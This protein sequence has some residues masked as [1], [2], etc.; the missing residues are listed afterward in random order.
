M[1]IRTLTARAVFVASVLGLLAGGAAAQSLLLTQNVDGDAND[2]I[3]ICD[4]EGAEQGEVLPGVEKPGPG[5][6]V[7]ESL[8]GLIFWAEENGGDHRILRSNFRSGEAATVLRSG[9]P[10]EVGGIG[11][12]TKKKFL[13]YTAGDSIYRMKI[14]G[15]RHKRVSHKVEQLGLDVGAPGAIVIDSEA[16]KVYWTDS[17]NDWIAK[18]EF[19]RNPPPAPLVTSAQIPI[20]DPKG[21]D[22]NALTG[23]LFWTDATLGTV[24]RAEM[25]GS[26]PTTVASNLADPDGVAID[27][28]ERTLLV[29]ESGADQVL[30]MGLDGSDPQPVVQQAGPCIVRI[31][32]EALAPLLEALTG[33]L[34]GF[35]NPGSVLFF[36]LV[37]TGEGRTQI[38][39]TNTNSNH[40]YCGLGQPDIFEGTVKVELRF[41]FPL[42]D[43]IEICGLSDDLICLTPNDTYTV[44]ADETNLQPDEVGW[45]MAFA[46]SVHTGEPIIFNHL[47]GSAQVFTPDD[48]TAWAYDA[49]SFRG[50]NLVDFIAGE[51]EYD[52]CG[53]PF[54]ESDIDPLSIEGFADFNDLEYDNFPVS[55]TLPVLFEES[56]PISNQL[57]VMSTARI[58]PDDDIF[59]PEDPGNGRTIKALGFNNSEEQK[60]SRDSDIICFVEGDLNDP[61]GP[62][63]YPTDNLMGEIEDT[64]FPD[65]RTDAGW[66]FFFLDFHRIPTTE[67]EF[68]D[69]RGILAT[70]AQFNSSDHAGG[71]NVWTGS[72]VLLE[73]FPILGGRWARFSFEGAEPPP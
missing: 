73:L 21:L 62:F 2:R 31:V 66:M 60:F 7:T 61:D 40:N 8:T 35:G 70:F 34:H 13:Y 6:M 38:T 23:Y 55:L 59:P 67:E 11:F 54:V 9:I 72:P 58:P 68:S 22:V 14:D 52:P 20:D 4:M 17:Q 41:V 69:L 48:D 46:V 18:A 42:G 25:D 37:D 49:Y 27:W 1:E 3:L 43:E 10:A 44:F 5:A 53:H 12:D 16:R 39:L 36:P 56:G 24:N 32:L 47:V 15:T 26:N 33:F 28:M 50:L 65:E 63:N 30:R 71:N 19:R 45:L 29:V 51:V 64:D 57:A